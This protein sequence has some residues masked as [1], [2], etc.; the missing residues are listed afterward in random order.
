MS[1]PTAKI[2]FGDN[3]PHRLVDFLTGGGQTG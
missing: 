1:M 2:V 3:A